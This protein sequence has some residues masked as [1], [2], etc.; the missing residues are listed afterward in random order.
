MGALR[1][2]TVLII[3][4]IVQGDQFAFGRG[5]RDG[6]FD[7][8]HVR[9]VGTGGLLHGAS[10]LGLDAIGRLVA[11]RKK[12]KFTLKLK[13]EMNLEIK[14]EIVDFCQSILISLGVSLN[15]FTLKAVKRVDY[16]RYGNTINESGVY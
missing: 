9:G 10:F 14:V 4:G 6:T 13:I 15:K 3:G 1:L 5:V 7:N 11:A 2:E 12:L 8:D 16:L